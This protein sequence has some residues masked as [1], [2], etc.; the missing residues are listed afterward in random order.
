VFLLI[1]QVKGAVKYHCSELFAV[2]LS[3]QILSLAKVIMMMRTLP[4]DAL[5]MTFVILAL[6]LGITLAREFIGPSQVFA[7][8][9]SGRI[10]L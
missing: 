4:S 5:D 10:E 2:C 9:E 3:P 1:V 8:L 7:F 6:E